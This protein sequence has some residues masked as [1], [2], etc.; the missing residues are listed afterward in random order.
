MIYPKRY[1]II[2]DISGKLR[3]YRPDAIKDVDLK[4]IPD[5]DWRIG[6]RASKTHKIGRWKITSRILFFTVSCDDGEIL[7]F[8]SRDYMGHRWR[9]LDIGKRI[10]FFKHPNDG[11]A[12]RFLLTGE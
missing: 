3:L 8:S 4:D 11:R 12:F 10:K 6:R 1:G 5:Y 9:R 7:T 2:T